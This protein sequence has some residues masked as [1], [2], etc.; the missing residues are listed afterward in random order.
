MPQPHI[1]Y[2]LWGDRSRGVGGGRGSGWGRNDKDARMMR[3]DLK[4]IGARG[5]EFDE[6]EYILSFCL[7]SHL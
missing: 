4:D 6:E 3:S 1:L 5:V 2:A 7:F